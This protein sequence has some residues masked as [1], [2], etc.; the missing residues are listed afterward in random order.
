MSV[1][2]VSVYTKAG[3][4]AH[5]QSTNGD[6]WPRDVIET[7]ANGEVVPLDRIDVELEATAAEI[8]NGAPQR[9]QHRDA[10]VLFHEEL[11]VVRGIV[12]Y[13]AGKGEGR[14]IRNR[15]AVELPD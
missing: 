5:V 13:R 4:I 11:E 6:T 3:V 2:R 10:G 12:R 15:T 1:H 8:A 9:P 7:N 14:P